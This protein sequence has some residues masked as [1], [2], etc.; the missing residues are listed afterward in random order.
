MLLLS[1]GVKYLSKFI[2]D[3]VR[4]YQ[5]GKKEENKPMIFKVG[6]GLKSK[7]YLPVGPTKEAAKFSSFKDVEFV[8]PT[9]DGKRI[10]PQIAQAETARRVVTKDRIPVPEKSSPLLE[11]GKAIVRAPVRTLTSIGLEPAAGMTALLTGGKIEPI[12]TPKTTF[13][14][15]IFGNEPVVGIFKQV[16]DT[17]QNVLNFAKSLNLDNDFS[18][19]ASFALSP[20]IVGG[21]AGLDLTPIGG[22]E[23][24]LAKRIAKETDASKIFSLLQKNFKNSPDELKLISESLSF[25]KNPVDVQ[26]ALNGISSSALTKPPKE[27]LNF[28]RLNLAEEEKKAL[29]VVLD[30]RSDRILDAKGEVLS[31][32]EVQ[33]A[34][35]EAVEDGKL[36]KVVIT[37][38]ESK[39]LAVVDLQAREQLVRSTK[40]LTGKG[41]TG[42]AKEQAFDE[43]VSALEVTTS[44][45][46]DAARRLS[47]RRITAEDPITVRI[48]KRMQKAGVDLDQIK[49]RATEVDWNNAKDVTKFFREFVKPTAWDILEEYRY[50]NMLSNP[51]TF[52]RNLFS[53]LFQTA[54]TRPLTIGVEAGIDLVQ[55][56]VTF[57]KIPRDK[58]LLDVPRYYRDI[59]RAVPNAFGD[60][61]AAWREETMF[62]LQDLKDVIPTN[63]LPKLFRVPTRALESTDRFL[64]R[65]ITDAEQSRLIRGGMEETKAGRQADKIAKYSLFRTGLD[66]K[67]KSGQ[68][69]LL[70]KIDQAIGWIDSGRDKVP[71]LKWFIPFVRTPM[72]FA[73]QW[74]EFSPVGLL[75]L[76]GAKRKKE[77]LAKF[78]IGSAVTSWGAKLALE[79]KT[80]WGVPKNAAQ[81]ELFFASGKRP[82]SIKVGDRW[83]PMMYF[84]PLGYA[85]ALPAAIKYI[86]EDSPEAMTDSQ[87]ERAAK[88]VASLSE[89]LSQQTFME[90]L[91]N[92]IDL[93]TGKEEYNI[94]KILAFTGGQIIPWQGMVRYI[95]TL[96]D[97][98]YRKADSFME[99]VQRD[100]PYLSTKLEPYVLPTGEKSKRNTS[101]FL[102][103]Y[104]IGKER[105]EYDALLQ[106]KEEQLQVNKLLSQ[107]DGSINQEAL[108]LVDKIQTSKSQIELDEVQRKLEE[109]PELKRKVVS[110]IKKQAFFLQSTI[111][112][113]YY[114]KDKPQDIAEIIYARIITSKTD[115]EIQERVV[116][117]IKNLKEHDL[118]SEKIAEKLKEI[119]KEEALQGSL[120]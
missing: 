114:L 64:M 109:N 18:L 24:N 86:Q 80:T 75:N 74:I 9:K 101:S 117:Y 17:Q 70:S 29:K 13:Q 25:V 116:D 7:S 31:F 108:S 104:D 27:L 113:L 4:E 38:E 30:T 72:N 21:F 105:E 22:V 8:S 107:N 62:S 19:G 28:E 115:K 98:V 69:L 89:F 81:R 56:L 112:P 32:K 95:S 12:F 71:T 33:K 53:N 65:M 99:A 41:V 96:V 91:G 59:W 5:Q 76:A 106:I 78:I 120:E 102:A 39:R 77:V 35:S 63:K 67:N 87:M 42:E 119:M 83:V 6:E 10:E 84:G 2:A 46:T 73:K 14:K 100:L 45:G 55:H 111:Q 16:E 3:S 85:L 48:L 34:A 50:N 26:K 60:F 15:V 92:W 66:P 20:I 118:W 82:Y 90:G 57:G 51:R 43:I 23:K 37:R 97:P 44:I 88:S 49:K 68:G 40:I 103:P 61:K 110:L 93:F 36:L 11:F 54:V 79:D 58:K 94:E 47:L 1:H 52:E